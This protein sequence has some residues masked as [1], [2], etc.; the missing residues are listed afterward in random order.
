MHSCN[1][2]LN[3]VLGSYS[4]YGSE[5]TLPAATAEELE[6]IHRINT[7]RSGGMDWRLLHGGMPPGGEAGSVT[8]G[9]KPAWYET[10][11]RRRSRP[12]T[13]Y[14]PTRAHPNTPTTGE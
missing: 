9:R 4:D 5:W 12:H 7:T 1:H 8:L 14:T 13:S 10:K 6:E 3:D 11:S 2:K